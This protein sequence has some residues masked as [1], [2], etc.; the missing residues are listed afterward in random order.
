MPRCKRKAR[1]AD[2]RIENWHIENHKP[3]SRYYKLI[4]ALAEEDTFN[5]PYT[6]VIV[7]NTAEM[8][9]TIVE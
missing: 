2:V 9:N 6:D 7:T 3:G 4:L 5:D 8:L 1:K